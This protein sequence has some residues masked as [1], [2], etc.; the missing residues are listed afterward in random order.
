MFTDIT[1]TETIT[2]SAPTGADL[3][4]RDTR[5]DV[6]ANIPAGHTV[7]LELLGRRLEL[8]VRKAD[9]NGAIDWEC[10]ERET[11]AVQFYS[12]NG[13]DVVASAVVDYLARKTGTLSSNYCSET[14]KAEAWAVL[15]RCAGAMGL[16]LCKL[17][18]GPKLPGEV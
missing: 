8:D 11:L 18:A 5:R 7:R 2:N 10:P 3:V 6:V 12:G 17:T 13:G 9:E 4:H 14:E 15:Q 16:D 1:T